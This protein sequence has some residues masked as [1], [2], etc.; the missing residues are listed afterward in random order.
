MDLPTSTGRDHALSTPSS[1]WSPIAEERP[2]SA[3]SAPSSRY[4]PGVKEDF[5]RLYKATYQRV[6]AT[7]VVILH[8]STAA[9]DATQEAYLR[10]FRG[11]KSWKQEAPA[12]AWIYR[13]A[14]NVAFTHRRRERLHE[15]GELLRRLGRPRDPDP[16]DMTQ[17][18]LV[19]EVRALP[20]KQ[21]AALVLRHLH[22]F[23]NREI[24]AALGVP[25]RTVASRLAAAKTRLRERLGS[26]VELELGTS[27]TSAVPL[28]D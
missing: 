5:D 19:R 24:G 10:A 22:G 8:D 4:R 2:A 27:G 13:I 9:E 3:Q 20:R 11:W 15:V 16:S 12:E 14:L 23:S 6:Y 17:P 25:E 18:D 1:S 7:L 21:A 26:R 28:D